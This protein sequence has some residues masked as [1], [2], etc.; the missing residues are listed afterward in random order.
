M[1]SKT[2]F[3]FTYGTLMSTAR[4]ALGGRERQMMQERA[5]LIGAARMKGRLYSAGACPGAVPSRS[6]RRHVQGEL[7]LLPSKAGR[8]LRCLDRYEGCLGRSGERAPYRRSIEIIEHELGWKTSAYVYVWNRGTAGL[9]ELDCGFWSE[10]HV[11]P[12]SPSPALTRPTTCTPFLL[13]A[14]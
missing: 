7:W 2:Q 9:T 3:I 12:T 6:A 1:R 13:N 14:A 8:M 11:D 10:G 5:R 4:T